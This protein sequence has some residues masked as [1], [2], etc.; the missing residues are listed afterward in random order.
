MNSYSWCGDSSFTISGY[1]GFPKN[2]TGSSVPVFFSEY[3]C[4]VPYPRI[5]TEVQSIYGPDLTN[6][7]AGG[8]VY[9]YSQ[10]PSNFGLVV[11]NDNGSVELKGDYDTLQKQFNKLSISTLETSKPENTTV[12]PPKCNANL[13]KTSFFSTNFTLPPVPPG[14]QDIINNGVAHPNNGKIVQVTN[15][16]VAQVVQDSNGNVISGLKLRA[17]ADN[18]SNLPNGT[19]TTSPSSSGSSTGSSPSSSATGKKNA[20]ERVKA[21]QASMLVALFIGACLLAL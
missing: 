15:L 9:E 3:G 5:F 1:D 8:L 6:T 7:L 10:E 12:T 4:N 11:I 13:I 14:A 21:T 20:G 19:V 2:F 18:Q 17:L 16:N